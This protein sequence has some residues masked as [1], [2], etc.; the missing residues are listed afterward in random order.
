MR[1]VTL[2]CA[3][4]VSTAVVAQTPSSPPAAYGTPIALNDALIL[5]QHGIELS[6][7]RGLKT[8][9]AVVEPSGELVA[10]ARMDDAPYGSIQ[11]AQQKARTSAR[12][13]L[14]TANAEERIQG[15]RIALVTA[16]DFVAIGGGV[17][18]VVNDRVVGAIGVSGATAAEDA[19]LA[20]A[21]LAR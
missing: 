5:V 2:I 10:F 15:G 21:M 12:F 13:R 1:L 11:L 4:L 6:K 14:T 3:A 7:A 17:P 8:A 20:S 16:D 18:I 19:A 9:I